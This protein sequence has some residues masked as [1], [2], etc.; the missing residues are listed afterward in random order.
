MALKHENHQDAKDQADGGELEGRDLFAFLGK[1]ACN[2][3]R[4]LTHLDVGLC[5]LSALMMPAAFT[6][7]VIS[8]VRDCSVPP[9]THTHTEYLMTGSPQ[10]EWF[11]LNP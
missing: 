3:Q 7:H 1:S 4:H 11:S 8:R 6:C 5:H 9:H 10:I 2:I